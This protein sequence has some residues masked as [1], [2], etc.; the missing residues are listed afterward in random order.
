MTEMYSSSAS[1]ISK[2]SIDV[3]FVRTIFGPDTTIGNLESAKKLKN[4]EKITFK[5][6]QIKSLPMHITYQKFSFDIFMV[7]NLQNIVMK[8]DLLLNILIMFGIREKS[9]ILTHIVGYCYKYT[10]SI[11]WLVLWFRVTFKNCI[12]TILVS[13]H[14][15]FFAVVA[16]LVN[17]GFSGAPT[18]PP[19][20]ATSIYFS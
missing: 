19:K 15:S 10:Q 8:R 20:K 4:I 11:L 12:N 5:V 1:W 14:S 13:D 16:S 17:L 2:L 9:I 6:V 18:A 3:W 7:G